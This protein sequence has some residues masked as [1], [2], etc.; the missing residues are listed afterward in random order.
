M[1]IIIFYPLVLLL[2]LLVSLL[3]FFLIHFKFCIATNCNVL[4]CTERSKEYKF[5][6]IIFMYT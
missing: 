5:L 1:T 2:V 6:L 3:I 4:H